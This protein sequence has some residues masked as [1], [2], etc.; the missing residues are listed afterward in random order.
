LL[1]EGPRLEARVVRPALMSKEL[2]AGPARFAAGVR[3]GSP[4]APSGGDAS[5]DASGDERSKDLRRQ[6]S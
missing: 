3:D 6:M 5:A 2:A 1:D 4:P